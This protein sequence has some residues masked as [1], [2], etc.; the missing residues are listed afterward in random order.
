M[1]KEYAV[2]PC[3]GLDKCAGCVTH[4]MAVIL[5][6]KPE[7]EI[8]C[9]VFYRA[10]E[11]RYQRILK[12]KALLVIDGCASRCASKLAAE[13]GLRIDEKINISEEAKRRGQALGDSLHIGETER[14]L[15]AELIERLEGEKEREGKGETAAAFPETLEY[16]SYKKEKFVFRVPITQGF[17]FTENDVW[18]YVSGGR[19]RIGITDFA[20]KSLSDIIF[21]MPPETGAEIGQFEEA[22]TVESGKAV[23]EVICPVSGVV[24]AVNERLADEPELLNQD[25][26]GEGWIAELELTNFEEDKNLLYGFREY[27]PIMKGKVDDFHV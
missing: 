23:F 26:Y 2:L 18:A 1:S 17:Y 8:V 12:E 15:I 21:F 5:S 3:N 13:K 19:A 4:E 14:R 11:A 27:F 22:G 6:E 24:R 16:E 20:Q 10:A 7:N 9:P 25:P